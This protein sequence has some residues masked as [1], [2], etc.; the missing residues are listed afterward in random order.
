MCHLVT[1]SRNSRRGC[2]RHYRQ[3]KSGDNRHPRRRFIRLHPLRTKQV[4]VP[5]RRISRRLRGAFNPTVCHVSLCHRIFI[6][7]AHHLTTGGQHVPRTRDS[8]QPRTR[9]SNKR[10]LHLNIGNIPS[11]RVGHHKCVRHPI[12]HSRHRRRGSLHK[13]QTRISKSINPHHRRRRSRHKLT[14]SHR[15]IS[16][17]S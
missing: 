17:V 13:R 3:T 12:S 7:C 8:R 16:P 6:S 4:C 15:V 14:I 2:L 5:Y 1:D 10:V 9:R 11:P